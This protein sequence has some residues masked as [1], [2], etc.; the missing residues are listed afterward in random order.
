MKKIAVVILNWNGEE[1]LK[2]FIPSVVRY[3]NLPHAEV[4]IVVADNGSTDSSIAFLQAEFPEVTVLSMGKNYGFAGG[5]NKALQQV[6]AD[7]AV[8]LN[9]DVEVSPN[10]L[11]PMFHCL[12]RNQKIAAC[13]PTIKSWKHREKFEYAGAAGGFIDYLGYP[14][15]RG[16]VFQ[17]VESDQGQY[18]DQIPIFWAS[19]ACLFIRQAI[20]REMGGFDSRFFAHMEEIDLCWRINARGYQIVS[21]PESVVYHVGAATLKKESH[22]KTYLNFRNNLLMLYKNLPSRNFKK[23]YFFRFFLDYLAAVNF[24][25][26]GNY[27]NAK[28]VFLARRDFLRVRKE[29]SADR[30]ENLQRM[31]SL[32]LDVLINSSI[33]VAYY[34]KGRKTFAEI[35]NL[36]N[37]K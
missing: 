20:F 37:K 15:C 5:Y 36:K 35:V 22:R 19:G 32:N 8:V 18:A 17:T 28:S 9:S 6:E 33:L 24:T 21:V 31:C 23:V 26:E 27:S 7:Y 12:E 13:Q 30:K 14:F 2:K 3:S 4:E 11:E 29:F 10:W 1:L 16:R 25:L 34:L